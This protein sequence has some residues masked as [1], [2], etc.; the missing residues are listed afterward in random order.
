MVYNN[1][2]EQANNEGV[3]NMSKAITNNVSVVKFNNNAYGVYAQNQY[4]AEIVFRNGLTTIIKADGVTVVDS[5]L[6]AF[7][8]E[9]ERLNHA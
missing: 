3:T 8:T 5:E 1:F 4:I 7:I 2:S 9:Y 6:V